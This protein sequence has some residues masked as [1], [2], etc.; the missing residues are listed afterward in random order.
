MGHNDKL[1]R[2]QMFRLSAS[3]GVCAIA[4]L[5]MSCQA[6]DDNNKVDLSILEWSGYQQVQ[7]HPEYNAKYG[8]QPGIALFAEEKDAMQRMRNGY[9]VDLV[10][11]CVNSLDE[12]RAAGLIKPLDIS[13]IPRWGDISPSLLEVEDV[14]VDGEYWLAPWEWGFSTV[15]YN[16]EVIEVENATYDIFVDPRFKG[17][18]ALTSSLSVNHIIAGIIG[19][20][21][22]PLDPTDAEM[23]TAPEIFRKMLE[24]A[25]FI[26]SDG[27][28]L[29]QAWVAGDVSIS[30]VFGSASL[31]MKRTGIP[32]VVVE[33]LMTWM[34]GLSLSANGRGS[35]EQAYDYINAMLD[36]A[37]GVALFDTYSYGHAN[38]KTVELLDP[39]RI[40]GLGID[41]PAGFFARGLFTGATPPAKEAKLYQLWFEAQAG[42]D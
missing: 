34:C 27:T 12:A 14:Q 42:L 13:R 18:T 30:Y 32:I 29:E 4:S 8:G 36:P 26:W 33:P 11:L 39:D 1:T 38:A 6:A 37:S 2:R 35:E 3:V 22:D 41:D 15:A 16:P 19:G 25:R 23:E 9:Q 10:H 28:Q 31:R 7:Y 40:E 17:K 5:L 21:A 24:N 20:W